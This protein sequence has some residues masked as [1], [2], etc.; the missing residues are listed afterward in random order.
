MNRT[1]RILMLACALCL[2][3]KAQA[4]LKFEQTDIELHPTPADA[5]A[6]AHFKYENAGSKPIHI[7]NVQT[8][9]GCTVASLKSNDVAPGDKGEITATLSIGN[10]TGLQH[11]TLTVMTDDP[12]HPQTI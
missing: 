12:E 2:T 11:K 9:C 8:S 1:T 7:S 3:A 10:R 6:V 5:N 4:E